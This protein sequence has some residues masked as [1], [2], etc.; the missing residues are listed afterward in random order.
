[1]AMRH[2]PWTTWYIAAVV[3]VILVLILRG[4]G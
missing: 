2:Y 1:M 4:Q 3:T